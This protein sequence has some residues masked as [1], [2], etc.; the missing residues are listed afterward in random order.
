M[1][2]ST[3]LI[4]FIKGKEVNAMYLRI[5]INDVD[6]VLRIESVYSMPKTH[7][8]VFVID[9]DTRRQIT[10]RYEDEIDESNF[11]I[12]IKTLL[13]EG[14]LDLIESCEELGVSKYSYTT[15]EINEWVQDI[16]NSEEPKEM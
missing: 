5:W 2:Y 6:A 9:N 3:G 15:T 11:A 16:L 1:E 14:Y 12:M 4:F 8:I 7:T 10:V 13:V